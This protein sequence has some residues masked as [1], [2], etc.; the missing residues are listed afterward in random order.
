MLLRAAR[1]LITGLLRGRY[2]GAH[3]RQH[4]II[5]PLGIL[6]YP[7]KKKKHAYRLLRASYS[8]SDAGLL[9]QRQA[10]P[11]CASKGQE[12][13]RAVFRLPALVNNYLQVI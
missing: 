1:L 12:P 4:P 9:K 11:T 3:T 5:Y 7:E 6:R 2:H 13:R 8:L 10:C